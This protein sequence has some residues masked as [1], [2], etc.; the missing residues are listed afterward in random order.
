M[1]FGKVLSGADGSGVVG[2]GAGGRGAGGGKKCDERAESQLS[3]GPGLI[4]PETSSS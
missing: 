4:V 1:P 3:G 2:G